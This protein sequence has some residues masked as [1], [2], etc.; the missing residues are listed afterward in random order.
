[1]LRGRHFIG[2][3][4]ELKFYSIKIKYYKVSKNEIKMFCEE[5]TPT[6]GFCK[7]NMKERTAFPSFRKKIG[8][9]Q[10]DSVMVMT[11]RPLYKKFACP[12]EI[13]GHA[14]I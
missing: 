7:K 10:F 8:G 13:N 1:M 9:F 4:L 11:R 5:V 2:E 3:F 6:V 12:D 14:R